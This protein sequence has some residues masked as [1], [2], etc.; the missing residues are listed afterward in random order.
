V[1][2]SEV[3]SYSVIADI[4]TCGHSFKIHK[5]QD[6]RGDL[7]DLGAN[8]LMTANMSLLSNV[9]RLKHPIIIVLAVSS[10]GTVSSSSECTHIGD[11]TIKCD[12]YASKSRE[13][14][15]RSLIVMTLREYL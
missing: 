4:G 13:S 1:R 7:A 15:V 11:L 14:V 2:V 5:C 9:Q 6:A 3:M 8:C 12:D 10:E